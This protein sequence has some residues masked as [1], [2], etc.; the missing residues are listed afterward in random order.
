MGCVRRLRTRAGGADY[1]VDGTGRR[2][3]H[4]KSPK[5]HVLHSSGWKEGHTDK[6][7]VVVNTRSKRVGFR[8]LIIARIPWKHEVMTGES[9]LVFVI[10][11]GS[12]NEFVRFTQGG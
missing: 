4:P 8:G 10:W 2:C 9:V 3:V 7:L 11:E 6:H 12:P 5:K 1:I